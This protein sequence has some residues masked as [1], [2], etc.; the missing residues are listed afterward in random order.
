MK[1]H[2]GG[3]QQRLTWGNSVEKEEL[4][5]GVSWFIRS[6]PQGFESRGL[7]AALNE[8]LGSWEFEGRPGGV[9][10]SVREV[11]ARPLEATAPAIRRGIQD[12]AVDGRP[13]NN[14]SPC[15][16]IPELIN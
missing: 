16:V 11:A 10:S 15:T 4:S 6:P 8:R 7:M 12:E 2:L 3:F 1:E 9:R 14:S 5:E 13:C